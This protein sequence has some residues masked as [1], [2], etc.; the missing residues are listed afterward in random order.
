MITITEQLRQRVER[1]CADQALQARWAAQHPA[2]GLGTLSEA[3]DSMLRGHEDPGGSDR[4]ARALLDLTHDGDQDAACLLLEVAGLL[5]TG[6]AS[7]GRWGPRG[8]GAE[9]KTRPAER[10]IDLYGDLALSI[11]SLRTHHHVD[12]V[13]RRVVH[14]ALCSYRRRTSGPFDDQYDHVVPID[15]ARLAW[16][17]DTPVDSVEDTV[18]TRVALG[19]WR[20]AVDR[21]INNG[22][23]SPRLRDAL[24]EHRLQPALTG[25]PQ[26]AGTADRS[27][28]WR[29][30][31][32]LAEIS[33]AELVAT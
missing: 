1:I 18:T 20:A 32:A 14:S 33:H 15:P 28:A 30:T 4:V 24:Y 27:R 19:Q 17:A 26:T 9:T 6:Y 12:R 7:G 22:T 5:A 11:A 16:T 25:Q 10:R 3:R 2:M 21:A 31:R 13:I 29:A 8:T 23:I